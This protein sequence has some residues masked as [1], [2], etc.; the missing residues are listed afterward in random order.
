[1]SKKKIAI[2]YG[3]RSVEHGVSINSARNIFQYIDLTRFE[4]IPIGIS[5]GGT[6]YK[7]KTISK[8]IE[9]G[10]ELSLQLNPASPSFIT[11]SGHSFK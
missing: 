4:P 11:R 10:E 9:T 1:M 6:W 3:G 8:E 7:T 2:L 5:L